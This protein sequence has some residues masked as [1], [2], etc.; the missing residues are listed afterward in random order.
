MKGVGADCQ[1]SQK[2][3]S[4]DAAS[5]SG[6][7]AFQMVSRRSWSTQVGYQ[8]TGEISTGNWYFTAPWAPVALRRGDPLSLRAGAD[9]FADLL[10][11]GLSNGTSDVRWITLLSWCLKWSHIVWQKAQS[12]A[13][14]SRDAQ[15][16][17]YAWLRPLEL[18]W[19][20]R[21]LQSGQNDGQLRGRRRVERWL[22]SHCKLADFA[23]N[24]EQF[25]RYR[26]IGTYGAYRVAFRS[27]PGL[28]D[29]NG[30]TPGSKALALANIVNESLP[31]DARLEEAHFEHGTRWGVWS[32]HNKQARYW[33][34][35][36]W[37][38]WDTEAGQGLLPTK[39][40]AIGPVLEDNEKVLIFC[41]HHAVA[42][43]LLDALEHALP[44]H[45]LTR[46]R[47][48]EGV[49]RQAWN[50]V[51]EDN[52]DRLRKPLIDWLCSAGV[53]H[54]V[55]GWLGAPS[56]TFEALKRTVSKTSPTPY[57]A[58]RGKRSRRSTAN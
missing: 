32:E 25:R 58:P 40:E 10:A 31:E 52:G 1:A 15:R 35:R 2:A 41:H 5:N 24:H 47:T 12:G 55:A 18:L 3:A 9:Y 57:C 51:L 26:Q 38:H 28:A 29:D 30:W 4:P 8:T 42:A 44:R 43:E 36:G 37:A 34:E 16:A 45:D 56:N 7:I 23:M 50:A 49:W 21:A 46:H 17:R 13:L 39:I 53:R 54:Q 11:P 14:S 27:L 33:I 20:A 6:M 19:I 48:D 22:A